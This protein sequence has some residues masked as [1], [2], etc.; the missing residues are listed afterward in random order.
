MMSG[1]GKFKKNK[2]TNE[3]PA[4]TQLALVFRLFLATLFNASSTIISTAALIPKN[5]ADSVGVLP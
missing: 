3:S 4:M 1:K 5:S 2:A